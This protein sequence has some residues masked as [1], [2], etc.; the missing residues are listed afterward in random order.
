MMIE[1]ILTLS[2]ALAPQQAPDKMPEK[3]RRWLE[4][5]VVWII[6]DEERRIFREL[7]SNPQR[8][9][10]IEEFWEQRDPTKGTA[11]NEFKEEHYRR[12][13]YANTWLGRETGKP[14]WKTDRGRIY[15]LLGEPRQKVPYYNH[16]TLIPQERW[17]YQADPLRG[18]PPFFNVIFFK[19][20]GV[21][22]YILYDPTIHGPESLIFL[23]AGQ[24]FE[25]AAE[26]IS[27]FDY[28]LALAS[29]NLVPTE[30]DDIVG[31]N[32]PTLSSINLI[33]QID[34][35]PNYRRDA[36]YARR[37]LR[38]EPRVETRYA[39]D[40]SNVNSAFD[41]ITF[42]NGDSAL[43]YA[44]HFP[45]PLLDYGKH[46]DTAYAAL[47]VILTVLAEDETV[48]TERRKTIEHHIPPQ[49]MDEYLAGG[50]A[51]EDNIIVLPGSYDVSMTIRNRVARVFYVARGKIDVP[52][53]RARE[54]KVFK[55]LLFNRSTVGQSIS[56][57]SI[58][59]YAFYNTRFHPVMYAVTRG[60]E[61]GVFYQIQAP[62]QEGGNG[63]QGVTVTYCLLDE[64]GNVVSEAG[65]ELVPD[66]FNAL[67]TASAFWSI[68]TDAYEIGSYTLQIDAKLGEET[69]KAPP[70]A[71]VIEQDRRFGEPSMEYGNHIDFTG[72]ETSLEKGRQ[73]I[74]LGNYAA[75]A[76][77]LGSAARQWPSSN[78]AIS[79]YAEALE[80]DSHQEEAIDVLLEI[81][82][83]DSRNP[84]WKRKLGALYLQTG[85]FNKAI[86][87]LEQVRLLEGETEEVLNLLGEAYRFDGRNEKAQEIWTLSLEL[88]PD[89][90]LISRRLE[91]LQD[92]SDEPK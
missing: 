83:R 68:K 75:A 41:V 19:K 55:P 80:R 91:Y 40:A 57:N 22:D 88:N 16:R 34:N 59:P 18:V 26:L 9:R 69:S 54:L 44:F 7:K 53:Y 58:P 43:N 49:R 12:I 78:E 52:P 60:Q 38:G 81:S 20:Y 5:E 3:Y 61:I 72:P 2:M 89:Q 63:V 76:Q 85:K 47:D 90:P 82:L 6:S 25:N 32:R 48:V 79:L 66:S 77:I 15:I 31:A 28:E 92:E 67:G 46:E 56:P 11:V 35:I 21:G 62:V 70:V 30:Q 42:A 14:G 1:L 86:G 74:N 39:F 51:F 73:L 24:S 27:E 33:S 71:I 17:F 36:E 64:K 4:E 13:E 50:L 37:I 10:F 84:L 87:Y 8:D 29:V 65:G 45:A 23:S